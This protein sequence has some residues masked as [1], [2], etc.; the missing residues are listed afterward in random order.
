MMKININGTEYP[1]Q[2]TMGAVLRFKHETGKEVSEVG[3]NDLSDLVTLIWC[4]VVSACNAEGTQFEM[5]LAKFADSMDLE[6]LNQFFMDE[7][8][9]KKKEPAGSPRA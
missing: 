7:T 2:M 5:D 4:C 6:T 8:A 3:S 1:C 9:D